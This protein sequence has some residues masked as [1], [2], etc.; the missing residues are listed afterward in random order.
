MEINTHS[1]KIVKANQL[2]HMLGHTDYVNLYKPPRKIKPLATLA[3]YAI[4]HTVPT[5]VIRTALATFH[6][7]IQL[8]IWEASATTPM[9]FDLPVAPYSFKCFSYPEYNAS[10]DCLEPRIIDPSHILTN[11]RLHATQK[12]FFDCDKNAFE[13]VSRSDNSILNLAL[14]RP[15]LPDKQSVPYAERIFSRNV[16]DIMRRNGDFR[17]ADMVM[18]IR[19]FYCACNERGLSVSTRLTHLV[20]MH[21]YMMDHYNYKSFPM[22]KATCGQLPP[23]TFQAILHNITTRIQLYSLSQTKTYNQRAVLTLAVE[24]M[25]STLATLAESSSGIPLSAK[26]PRYMSKMTQINIIHQN[27]QK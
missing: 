27:P 4:K 3:S 14:L 10:R 7:K 24:N 21:T 19:N 22:T 2:G 25:F 17:E 1:L 12:G 13:R 20:N 18:N 11:L 15:P 23:L 26:I 8:P 16:E 6:F 5:D 9:E